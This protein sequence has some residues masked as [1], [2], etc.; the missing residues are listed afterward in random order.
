MEFHDKVG[1]SV[2]LQEAWGRPEWP[3]EMFYDPL[4]E[5]V[6]DGVEWAASSDPVLVD[7][8]SDPVSVRTMAS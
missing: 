2:L 5:P 8:T 6:A 1:W 4:A 3:A 7:V